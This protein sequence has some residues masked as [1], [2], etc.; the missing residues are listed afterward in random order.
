[1]NNVVV[2]LMKSTNTILDGDSRGTGNAPTLLL[3][4]ER[5]VIAY[6]QLYHL[7]TSLASRRP[8]I[9][10]E[11]TAKLR[12]FIADPKFRLK[13]SVPDI[14][15]FIVMASL[16][17]GSPPVDAGQ[18]ITWRNHLNGPLLE[19]VFVRNVRWN[20]QAHPELEVL[21]EGTSQYRLE[22]T[23]QAAKTSLR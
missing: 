5:A 22:K 7:L 9:L 20:L 4:S 3:A 6:C 12:R 13:A 2:S 16:V 18:Q 17:L 8:A 23:F 11:A 15:E 19:E 1:M 14:G 21:E 10:C